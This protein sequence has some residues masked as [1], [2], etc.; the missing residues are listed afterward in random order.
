MARG[1]HIK[2]HWSEQRLF[3]QRALL[4]GA[5]IALLTIGLLGR[6]FLLQVIRHDYYTDLSQGN[7]VRTEPIPAARGLIL[8][9]HGEDIA[10]ETPAYQLELIPEE[11]PDLR[12]TLKSLVSLGI[13]RSDEIDELV[14]TIKSRRTF[15]SVPIRLRMSDEDVATFAVR[16]FEFPGLDIKTRQ[17]RWYPGG[18]L[19]VHALGYVGAIS[20]QDLAHIDRAAY[21]G[22]TLIGK[23]GV[24]SAYESQ[25][26]GT[27]GFREI[28]VNA[29]GRS[30]EHEGVFAANLRT[31]PPTAGDDVLLSVDLSVQRVAETALAGHRGAVVALDP[32]NGD[33]IALVSLPGF[34]PNMF[35]RGITSAEYRSL[36]EDIDR[37]LFNRALRGTYPPGSTVKPV[38][39]LAALTY[40]MVDPEQKHF[41]AGSFH[42]PGSAHIFREY[43]N[44]HHGY[45]DLDDAIAHSCDVYFYGL[46]NTLGVDRISTFM[47]PFGFGSPTGIDVGGEKSGLLPSRAWKAKA[48]A[49]PADQLWFPGETVNMGIGQGYLLVTP[50]QLAHYA[51]I[52]GTRGKIWKPRLVTGL[53]DPLS[54]QV[55]R[56][57]PVFEGQIT[58]VSQED[59]DRVVHG[60]IGVTQRGTAAAIGAH[61]PYIFGGKTGTAQVYTVAQNEHYN[62]KLIDERLRDH[63]WFI[64]FAPADSPR[65]AVAVLQENG[66]AGASAAAP[67]ARKVLDA[68]LLGPDGKLK[69]PL[70]GS[71]A[72]PSPT[73]STVPVP[74]APP[75]EAPLAPTPE[76][77]RATVPEQ[78]ASQ[79]GERAG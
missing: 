67:I 30:V 78:P 55:Q 72:E 52:M 8:D 48:F 73:P 18:P 33:I 24:E 57:K 61:A 20:E 26:H 34:D 37:P 62:A 38:I 28:L 56:L 66:G 7:R 54:G 58:G 69:A 77:K 29:Q 17:T 75:P 2:D 76:Q 16:R 70:P 53:R 74:A 50:L 1:V 6:L 60:M 44:E 10:A 21:A 25:L 35:G 68:Y 59:W 11:V 65:I 23:L 15:D 47:A 19:A 39:A 3:D 46:A 36:Q 49:R 22:T 63:S 27:N 13:L 51:G 31:K 79:P 32:N 14:R 42:L 64:A 12:A 45:V 4:A 71:P 43:H 9:R 40:H 41:C 5:C